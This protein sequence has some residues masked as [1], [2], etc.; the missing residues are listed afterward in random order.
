MHGKGVFTSKDGKRWQGTFYN[1]V[2]DG[3]ERELV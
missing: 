3:I 1:G 2:G